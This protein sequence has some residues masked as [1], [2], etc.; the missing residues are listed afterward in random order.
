MVK[1]LLASEC[2]TSIKDIDGCTALHYAAFTDDLHIFNLLFPGE[3]CNVADRDRRGFGLLHYAVEGGNQ[4]IVGRLLLRCLF[5]S[6]LA[7]SKA[8]CLAGAAQHDQVQGSVDVMNA[9][10]VACEL[11]HVSVT[12]YL[13]KAGYSVRGKGP[14]G[15]E[16]IHYASGASGR[17]TKKLT[18]LLLEPRRLRQWAMNE[19]DQHNIIVN[20]LLEKQADIHV[21]D[22][23]GCNALMYAAGVGCVDLVTRFL[24]MNVDPDLRD[25]DE[26]TSMHWAANSG[27]E[28][29]IGLLGKA[30]VPYDAC[31]RRGHLPLHRAAERGELRAVCA[32]VEAMVKKGSDIHRKDA[33]GFSPVHLA[34]AKGYV[35]VV[36]KLLEGA[37]EQDVKEL[38]GLHLG[39]QMKMEDIVKSLLESGNCDVNARDAEGCTP[40]HY[41]AET[42]MS[43]PLCLLLM[44]TAVTR[45][46]GIG[47]MAAQQGSRYVHHELRW[48]DADSQSRSRRPLENGREAH[49]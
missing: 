44:S 19:C 14:D 40:L 12:S 8:Y 30:G 43:S 28:T 13:I 32:F 3:G 31:D 9:L 34:A 10:H 15:L 33:E 6:G 42:G 4:E 22:D 7:F 20:M 2:D 1:T 46:A 25:K 11:G 38:T 36:T 17:D 29:I 45:A 48:N 49:R 24:E 16:P 23:L 18:T 27:N 35:D 37:K 47:G 21:V 5:S 26:A 41:A 39:I